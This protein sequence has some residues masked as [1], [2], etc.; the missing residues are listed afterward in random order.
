MPAR[1]PGDGSGGPKDVCSG[2]APA[3]TLSSASGESSSSGPP[4]RALTDASSIGSARIE[5]ALSSLRFGVRASPQR[6]GSI[7]SVNASNAASRS[8]E[9][10]TR[11]N[12]PSTTTDS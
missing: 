7:F 2:M 8:A 11:R 6:P 12:R 10:S 1:R 3:Q 9:S 5:V 4:E